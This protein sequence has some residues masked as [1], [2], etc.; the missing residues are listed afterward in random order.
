MKPDIEL[1]ELGLLVFDYRGRHKHGLITYDSSLQPEGDWCWLYY[2]YGKKLICISSEEKSK[3]TLTPVTDKAQVAFADE[4][5]FYWCCLNEDEI[6]RKIDA[7]PRNEMRPSP[8]RKCDKCHGDSVVYWSTGS[9]AAW[10][11]A[12]DRENFRD[13]CQVCRGAGFVDDI[14]VVS[15]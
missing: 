9:A 2:V 10:Q 8:K 3:L 4:Q 13:I 7:I 1:S 11:G 14:I 5:Y 6:K 15:T 12:S